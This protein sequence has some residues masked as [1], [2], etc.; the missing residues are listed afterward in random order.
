M[1]V[2]NSQHVLGPREL[3]GEVRTWQWSVLFCRGALLGGGATVAALV[4][5]V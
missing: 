3:H 1:G 2:V 4:A 5:R